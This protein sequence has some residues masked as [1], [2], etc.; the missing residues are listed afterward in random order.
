MSQTSQAPLAKIVWHLLE[1]YG[2]DPASLFHEVGFDPKLFNNPDARMSH[3]IADK[4]WSK[5]SELID[6]PCFGLRAIKYWHPTQ[7][8]ALG[9]A[10]LA[11]S[12]LRTGFNR[13][14]RYA[15]IVSEFINFQMEDTADGFVVTLVTKPFVLDIP[16]RADAAL[17]LLVNLCRINAGEELNPLVVTFTHEEFPCSGEYYAYFRSPIQFEAATNSFI[18]SPD[19]IDQQLDGANPQLAQLND[20]LMISTLAK[21]NRKNI[22]Q[23]VKAAI[24]EQLPSG[25]ISQVKVA[26]ALHMSVRNLQRKLKNTNTSFRELLDEMRR[27]LAKQYVNNS[28]VSLSEVTFLLGFSESSSFSRA[29]KRWHGVTPNVVRKSSQQIKTLLSLDS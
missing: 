17:S 12:S 4:L 11:S 20:Q 8:G 6:D 13:F 2:H 14:D 22:E 18:L 27:E 7:F 10:W 26:D 3:E 24:I 5:T 9:Y 19:M 29:Y 21:L 1:E 28:D 25:N 16:A 15:H 23:R